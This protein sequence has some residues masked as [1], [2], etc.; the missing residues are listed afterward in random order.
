MRD[1]C[2]CVCV[3]VCVCGVCVCVC[4]CV[5]VVCV[6]V[7]V[8]VCVCVCVYARIC[9]SLPYTVTLSIWMARGGLYG[10]ATDTHGHSLA[11]NASV[12]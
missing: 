2:V 10:H 3:C 1:L 12:P 7:C 11:D 8:T 4:V 9:A 5:C 6:C